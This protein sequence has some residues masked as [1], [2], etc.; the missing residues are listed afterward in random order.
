MFKIT[1]NSHC[2]LWT[3]SSRTSDDLK[4]SLKVIK[5]YQDESHLIRQLKQC[6]KCQQLYFYE[7]YE[8]IDWVDGNDPQYRT[9]IPVDDEST[10]EQLSHLSPLEIQQFRR[11]IID[12]PKDQ[13]AP[14]APR[15]II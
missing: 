15:K 7:F 12:W 2:H 10:A 9:W 13:P 1:E 11:I 6:Q 14:S 3:N 4:N 5:T 8:T